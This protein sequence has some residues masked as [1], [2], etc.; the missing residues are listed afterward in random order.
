MCLHDDSLLYLIAV[1]CHVCY[2]W[3]RNDIDSNACFVDVSF[4]CVLFYFGIVCVRMCCVAGNNHIR[5]IWIVNDTNDSNIFSVLGKFF[6][7]FYCILE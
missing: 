1:N 7:F 2:I 4:L 6:F 5:Y 3:I